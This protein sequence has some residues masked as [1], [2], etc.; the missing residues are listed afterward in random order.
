MKI[1]LPLKLETRKRILSVGKND[2]SYLN[3]KHSACYGIRNNTA[4]GIKPQM[5]TSRKYIKLAFSV[6][7]YMNQITDLPT[8][9]LL[10]KQL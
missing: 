4:H 2:H 5:N 6:L 9:I 8:S 7:M 3:V 1:Y 10:R